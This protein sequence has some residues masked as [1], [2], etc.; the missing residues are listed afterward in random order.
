[1]I[2]KEALK[3]I[4]KKS[5]EDEV[6]VLNQEAFEKATKTSMQLLLNKGKMDKFKEILTKY[7]PNSKEIA[8]FILVEM[9]EAE[10]INKEEPKEEVTTVFGC[11]RENM[12]HTSPG[13]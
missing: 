9:G 4:K 2:T 11:G 6:P 3:A 7:G 12:L 1:M 8:D 10:Q 5:K 13:K